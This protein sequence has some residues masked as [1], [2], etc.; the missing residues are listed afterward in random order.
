M[1]V[2][3][4]REFPFQVGIY[5]LDDDALAEAHLRRQALDLVAQCVAFN[6]W[7]GH[8]DDQVQTLSLPA[9]AF[10]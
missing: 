9:W 1:F 5:E 4:E 2:V 8:T 7:P 3:V 6:D 10:N